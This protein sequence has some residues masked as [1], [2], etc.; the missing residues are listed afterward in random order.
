MAAVAI[1]H[2]RAVLDAGD[3]A[4]DHAAG[5]AAVGDELDLPAFLAPVAVDHAH[6]GRV[7]ED[8]VHAARLGDAEVAEHAFVGEVRL[9]EPAVETHV[10]RVRPAADHVAAEDE[11][12]ELNASDL[13]IGRHGMLETGQVALRAECRYLRPRRADGWLRAHD[14]T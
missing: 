5:I 8:R 13:R 3:G 1:D 9:H 11:S 2:A 6:Q 14:F 10:A 7:R 12:G 4:L